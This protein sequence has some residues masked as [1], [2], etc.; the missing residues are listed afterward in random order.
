MN[1]IDT[2]QLFWVLIFF[3]SVLILFF[4]WAKSMVIMRLF[5]RVNELLSK[6]SSLYEKV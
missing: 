5:G 4:I 6:M 1:S 2:I 3:F